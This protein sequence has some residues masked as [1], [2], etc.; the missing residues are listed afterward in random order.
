[1][2]SWGLNFNRDL[3][4]VEKLYV[5]EQRSYILDQ[6]DTMKVFFQ[7]IKDQ[8][9]TNMLPIFKKTSGL[10]KQF[11]KANNE[12]ADAP[13]PP[14]AP[15]KKRA[16]V[17]ILEDDEDEEEVPEQKSTKFVIPNHRDVYHNFYLSDRDRNKKKNNVEFYFNYDGYD[18]VRKVQIVDGD[19]SMFH[20]IV[21]SYTTE[22][23]TLNEIVGLKN[24][25][26]PQT[27]KHLLDKY[28]IDLDQYDRFAP[29]DKCTE[30][31]E[32]YEY[33]IEE[34]EVLFS[35]NDIS[36]QGLYDKPFG[37]AGWWMMGANKYGIEIDD[38]DI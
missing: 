33:Y 6:N 24:F 13:K 4:I 25:A 2:S 5:S 3:A 12:T 36:L 19:E 37:Y 8:D 38:M 11:V 7:C 14:K 20:E 16:K 18:L 31:E 1:M 21:H 28:D 9:M 29:L 26:T 35:D 30:E 32:D 15:K 10:H 17:V 22:P 34:L 27:K 23:L